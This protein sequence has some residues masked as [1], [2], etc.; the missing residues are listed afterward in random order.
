VLASDNDVVDGV[1]IEA[2]GEIGVE[3][4]A[5]GSLDMAAFRDEALWSRSK[6]RHRS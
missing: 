1:P 6:K 5:F 4:H 3:W 2:F